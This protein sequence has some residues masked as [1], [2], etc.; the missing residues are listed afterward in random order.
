MNIGIIGAGNVGG[1]LG[2]GWAKAGHKIKFGVRDATKLEVVAL[3]RSVGANASAGS[4]ADAA[5][6]GEVVVLTTP[7]PATQA[8]IQ[9]AGT[10]AGKIVVDCTNPVKEDLS[11]LTVGGDDS[12][13]EQVA[14]WAKG[15]NV[16]KCFNTTGAGNMSNPKYGNDRVVMFLAGD[17]ALAKSTVDKLGRDLGFEMVDAGNLQ[18]S[19]FLE[20]LAALWIQ[21]AFKCGMGLDFGFKLIRR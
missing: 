10:L 18:V 1:A 8:A 16:V 5:A 6:F 19:R 7:W 21:L 20:P 9:S 17:N 13:G 15:A 2:G 11:G 14:Q 3:V 4:V 12:A